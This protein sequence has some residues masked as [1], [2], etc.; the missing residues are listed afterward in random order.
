MSPIGSGADEDVAVFFKYYASEKER[1]HWK[2]DFPNDQ[3]PPHCPLL[4]DRN[5][6]LPR[7]E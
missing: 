3:W 6:N 7:R 4:Y 1:R 5:R 2:S